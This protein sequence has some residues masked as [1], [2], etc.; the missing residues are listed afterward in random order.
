MNVKIVIDPL[1]PNNAVGSGHWLGRE[2]SNLRMAE[3]K[4]AALPLGYAPTTAGGYPQRP[5]PAIR[6]PAAHHQSG[7]AAASTVSASLAAPRSGN[8]T[9]HVAPLPLIRAIKAPG[10]RSSRASTAPISGTS[11]IAAPVRSLRSGISALANSIASSG[12]GT[13][14]PAAPNRPFRAAKT[15]AVGSSFRGLTSNIPASGRSAAGSIR[16]PI[17]PTQAACPYRQAGTSEPS[18]APRQRSASSLID[19]R[20]SA[21]STRNAAAA[22]LDPPPI[23]AAIGRFFSK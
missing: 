8:S 6:P 4:S 7:S 18:R 3:S 10:S 1:A 15:A 16:S 17:P 13:N 23:P 20:H 9:K 5:F 19:R 2:D 12:I 21:V 11:S 14:L 22:S